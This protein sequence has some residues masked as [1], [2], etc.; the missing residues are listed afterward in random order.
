MLKN[1]SHLKK[2]SDIVLIQE[3]HFLLLEEN[4]FNDELWTTYHSNGDGHKGV[5]I[6]IRRALLLYYIVKEI[7]LDVS[8]QGHVLALHF[9][10]KDPHG[11][12]PFTII[13]C[14]LYTGTNRGDHFKVKGEQLKHLNAIPVTKHLFMGGDF[15]FLEGR[16]DT[17]ST[18]EYHTHPEKF[19]TV[20]RKFKKKYNLTQ[21]HSDSHTFYKIC[22]SADK[23]HS[24]RLDRIYTT[25]SEADVEM[26]GLSL[27]LPNIP[28]NIL[29]DFNS[30]WIEE[31]QRKHTDLIS[32]SDHIPIITQ[33]NGKIE[34][35]SKPNIPVWVTKTKAFSEEFDRLWE[36]RPPARDAFEEADYLNELLFQ[37]SDYARR[38]YRAVNAEALAG[39]ERI[40][41]LIRLL[42]ILISFDSKPDE[43]TT[44][45]RRYP[46]LRNHLKSGD[47][48]INAEKLQEHI[49][50]AIAERF[51]EKAE[52]K[53]GFSPCMVNNQNIVEKLAAM[54]PSRRKR[55]AQLRADL[56]S[57]YTSDPKEMAELV[58]EPLA[59]IWAKHKTKIRP[60]KWLK[61]YSNTIPK[62]LMPNL[63]NIDDAEDAIA[64]T[65]DSCP[66]PDGIPFSAYR[67][68]KR[69]A[70]PVIVKLFKK[71]TE[72]GTNIPED[73][74]HGLL[75][76]IP[77]T[78]S[79]LPL[80]T[81]PIS[82]TNAINRIIAKLAVQAITPA[83]QHLIDRAQKG[84][85][86][87]RQG[88]DHINTLNDRFYRAVEEG[89]DHYILF[90]DTRKA[91]DSISHE[92]IHEVLK[93]FGLPTWFLTL[94]KNLL[95]NVLVNPVLGGESDIWIPIKQGVKQGCPLSPI[96]FAIVV[97]PLLRA[98]REYT[99]CDAYA[100]A[101]DLAI[102]TKKLK[103]LNLCMRI[104]DQFGETSGAKQNHGKTAILSAQDDKGVQRWIKRSPWK[105][106]KHPPSYTYLGILFG[107]KLE[108]ADV[109]KKAVLKLA[110]RAQEYKAIAK[111]LSHAKRVMIFNVFIISILSYIA[112][113]Y[114]FPYDIDPLFVKPK[115]SL[116]AKVRRAACVI[117]IPYGG[118]GYDYVHL[119]GGKDRIASLPPIRDITAL[120]YATLGA[121]ANLEEWDQLH[122]ED[123]PTLDSKSMQ[124]KK[125]I[126]AAGRDIVTY[127]LSSDDW[128]KSSAFNAHDLIKPTPAGS[129][130]RIYD[131]LVYTIY[132]WET[133]NPY[134]EEV[135]ARRQLTIH[136]R[137][138]ANE[139]RLNP[140]TPTADLINANYSRLLPSLPN[141]ARH[142]NVSLF[143]NSLPTT[144]RRRHFDKNTIK[145][146]M[147]E[148]ENDKADHLLTSCSPV[149][150]ALE[151]YG[152]S[153]K[154]G[155]T[156]GDL[157]KE[158][159]PATRRDI[160]Y[161]NFDGKDKIPEIMAIAIFNYSTWYQYR[162]YF[163]KL[164]RAND[165]QKTINRIASAALLE[166]LCISTP[167]KV[168]GYG[169]ANNRTKEQAEAAAEYVKRILDKVSPE[170]IVAY[171]DG[172]SLGNPGPTGAGAY[173]RYPRSWGNHD[174]HIAIPLG[175]GTNNIG[176]LYA[177]GAATTHIINTINKLNT[178][179]HRI[180]YIS[181]SSY[182]LGCL[183]KGWQS[184]KNKAL[185]RAVKETIR[186]IPR[187]NSN[188]CNWHWTPGHANVHGNNIADK[189][190][191]EGS[192]MS[193]QGLGP[194]HNNI[195][196]RI[197]SK[198][199]LIGATCTTSHRED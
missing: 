105:K 142:I 140:T 84:F 83:V 12:S 123:L 42:R 165:T 186:N 146:P 175:E 88:G 9:A 24:S 26:I 21:I 137:E 179:P 158:S 189:L 81:R 67:A 161:L 184:T 151:I 62:E 55:L 188:T 97:D 107:R 92:Y 143:F 18:T 187:S 85:I 20:W 96:I 32:G 5:V 138:E 25:F 34:G 147:C 133:Q 23:S 125:Q 199:F 192:L 121:K 118:N 37:A 36:A 14:Y 182:S 31:M 164:G 53:D 115:D 176:E 64:S 185:I 86:P 50:K 40:D 144:H 15:N 196:K 19:D 100:F 43:L 198:S 94:V 70:A 39:R 181:D 87:G 126:R 93:K 173:I 159:Y 51:A 59:R 155:I 27:A 183:T 129:R 91:F 8:L 172:S 178:N 101:D 153:L 167:K 145:C 139:I 141:Q 11:D 177:I 135:A 56:K 1:I 130:K 90:M 77:K 72:E 47:W 102:D 152:H 136:P 157:S 170:D 28:F 113:F 78:D 160:A 109:Y 44:L 193:K 17:T 128:G 134:V 79:G 65:N 127:H 30:P 180:F 174:M 49:N 61:F 74:N 35:N 6:I 149:S 171:T 104:V 131:R 10:P 99:H 68:I 58:K 82:V 190:A 63:P 150:K 112:N 22:S 132:T 119:V 156:A 103:K 122:R 7:K 169:N 60:K 111:E 46:H 29:S 194:D 95:R 166:H 66:G 162:D 106:L 38:H 52:N 117:I 120:S 154:L 54:L 75:F 57:D 124:I 80:D 191:N 3:T 71:L 108:V 76:L 73:F 98:L 41:V 2:H 197:K 89:D 4:A 148:Y 16:C 33:Y 13:N 69:H 110:E 48:G 116:L 168:K 45:T 114:I 163:R 195:R